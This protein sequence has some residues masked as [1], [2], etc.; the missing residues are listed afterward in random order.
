MNDPQKPPQ[1][2][3]IYIVIHPQDRAA[4]EE[5]LGAKFEVPP[6]WEVKL[7]DDGALNSL[8]APYVVPPTEDS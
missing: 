7:A 6:D 5:I 1:P 8:F 3:Y 4:W 2:Y